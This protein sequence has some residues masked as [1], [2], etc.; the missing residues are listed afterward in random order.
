MK[1][2]I[3]REIQRPPLYRSA[4]VGAGL[5]DITYVPRLTC[6][7]FRIGGLPLDEGTLVRTTSKVRKGELHDVVLPVANVAD[8]I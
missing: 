5:P 8:V 4:V 6:S 1:I 3:M 2:P 7:A